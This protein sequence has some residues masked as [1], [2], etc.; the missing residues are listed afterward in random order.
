[1]NADIWKITAPTFFLAFLLAG[2]PM[3]FAADNAGGKTTGKD[4]SQKIDETAYAIK[5]YI[6]GAARRSA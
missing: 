5:N 2:A 1:M 6:R 3:S 4:V